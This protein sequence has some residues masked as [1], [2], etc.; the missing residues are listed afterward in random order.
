M[1]GLSLMKRGLAMLCVVCVGSLFPGRD[2][3]HVSHAE[4]QSPD[5]WTAR[6]VPT[7]NLLKTILKTLARTIEY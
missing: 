2:Q 4:I 6:K 1:V 3:T 5:H 7:A